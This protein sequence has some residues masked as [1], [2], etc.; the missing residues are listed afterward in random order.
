MSRR[1]GVAYELEG[2]A[3]GL[4]EMVTGGLRLN[5]PLVVRIRIIPH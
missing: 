1:E 5:R 2:V 4:P 3:Y